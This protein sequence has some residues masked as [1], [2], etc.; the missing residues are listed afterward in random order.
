MQYKQ[1]KF[2]GPVKSGDL[3]GSLMSGADRQKQVLFKAIPEL[4]DQGISRQKR[5][6]D[7]ALIWRLSGHVHAPPELT[8]PLLPR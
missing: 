5:G 6:C 8:I 1:N 3:G 7:P 4:K 2:T